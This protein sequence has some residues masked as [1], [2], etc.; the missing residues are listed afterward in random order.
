M[1]GAKVGGVA[2]MRAPNVSGGGGDV[3]TRSRPIRNRHKNSILQLHLASMHRPVLL[4][5]S[6]SSQPQY[7]YSQYLAVYSD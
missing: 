1:I 7:M 6:T 5:Y 2:G 3:R 4:S